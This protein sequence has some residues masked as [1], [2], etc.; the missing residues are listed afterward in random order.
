MKKTANR[1]KS[2]PAWKSK[3]SPARAR[4]PG[5]GGVTAGCPFFRF[6]VYDKKQASDSKIGGICAFLWVGS[7]TPKRSLVKA[8]NHVVQI[9]TLYVWLFTR[10]SR[11][12]SFDQKFDLRSFEY[13]VV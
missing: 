7:C 3:V 13:A 2:Q 4:Q 1:A 11:L 5:S 9:K 8:C 6:F 10:F 12:R